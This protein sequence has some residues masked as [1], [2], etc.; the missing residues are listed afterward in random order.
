MMFAMVD[1]SLRERCPAASQLVAL[2]VAEMDRA[3]RVGGDVRD[4][5]DVRDVMCLTVTQQLLP[6]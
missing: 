4:V 2:A 1:D 6:G 5:R 3:D